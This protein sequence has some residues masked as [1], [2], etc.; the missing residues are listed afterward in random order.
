LASWAHSR[1]AAVP[2]RLPESHFPSGIDASA[3]D[4]IG[5]EL[6]R[7]VASLILSA[8]QEGFLHA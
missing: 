5:L 7:L 3:L 2:A 6:V 1:L 4:S 8:R